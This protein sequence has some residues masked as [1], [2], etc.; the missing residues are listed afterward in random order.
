MFYEQHFSWRNDLFWRALVGK[1]ALQNLVI[2]F[3]ILTSSVLAIKPKN[4]FDS[5]CL[6]I[7]AQGTRPPSAS[8]FQNIFI[9]AALEISIRWWK[10]TMTVCKQ[11]RAGQCLSNLISPNFKIKNPILRICYDLIQ[12]VVFLLWGVAVFSVLIKVYPLQIRRMNVKSMRN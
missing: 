2:F 9:Y 1:Y 3:F 10:L 4:H 12:N 7:H 6:Q 8:T 5:S 11:N